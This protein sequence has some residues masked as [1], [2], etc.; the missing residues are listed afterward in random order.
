MNHLIKYTWKNNLLTR[1]GLRTTDGE[2]VYIVAAGREEDNTFQNARVKIGD[3]EW[4]G[5]VIIDDGKNH[6]NLQ[7]TDNTILYVTDKEDKQLFDN[8]I[9]RLCIKLPEQLIQEYNEASMGR[10]LLPC[11]ESVANTNKI[12]LHSHLSRLLIERIED[13]AKHIEDLYSQCN[14]RWND[15]LFVLLSRNFGFGIKS[16]IFEEWAGMLDMNA[17]GKHRD[18]QLQVE[19]IFFGQA[20]LLNTEQIPSYYRNEALN[21][22]YYNDIVKEYSFLKNKFDLKSMESKKW[23]FGNSTPHLRIARLAKIY[24]SGHC[25]ISKIAECNSIE[26]IR[27]LFQIQPDGYWR[28]HLQ[29]GGTETSGTT[30]LR[31][32]QTDLIIINTVVPILY[33]YGKHRKEKELC[34][35]AEDLL[36]SLRPEE[37]SIIRRWRE[38]GIVIDC[39]ADSQALIQLNRS[40]CNRYRCNDCCFG[41]TYIKEQLL[42]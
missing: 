20:G 11:T 21:S 42:K 22:K 38:K 10:T 33:S 28:N 24:C 2:D 34:N 19:A 31:N 40:Y 4:I 3:K 18:N 16:E 39:A 36:H 26:E 8:K 6:N 35:K 41:Y 37:N 15:T 23:A 5:N 27:N 7:A 30:P 29:F 32:A 12:L 25:D 9:P 17:L 13:K 14:M 1:Y